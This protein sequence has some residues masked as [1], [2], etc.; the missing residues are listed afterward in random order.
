MVISFSFHTCGFKRIGISPF[1]H[2]EMR[3]LVFSTQ[4]HSPLG[5]FNPKE[6]EEKLH[7]TKMKYLA[8]G[9]QIGCKGMPP[10]LRCAMADTTALAS[11]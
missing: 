2:R 1:S 10:T 4:V 6:V 11:Q 8:Q 5:C 3:E 9:Q 7:F